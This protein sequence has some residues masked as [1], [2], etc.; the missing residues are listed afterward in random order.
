MTRVGNFLFPFSFFNLFIKIIYRKILGI[1][2]L[3]AFFPLLILLMRIKSYVSNE[4]V[5]LRAFKIGAVV[6]I[7]TE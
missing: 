7:P 6:L 4:V 1:K 2:L 5:N 3:A